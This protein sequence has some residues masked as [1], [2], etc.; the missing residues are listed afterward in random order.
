MINANMS[1]LFIT[2]LYLTGTIDHIETK[3]QSSLTNI[4][5][6]NVYYQIRLQ[7]L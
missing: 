2:L 6:T 3:G 4:T 7:T 5:F 1:F